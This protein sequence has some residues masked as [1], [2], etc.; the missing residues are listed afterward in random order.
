M[1]IAHAYGLVPLYRERA[2]LLLLN[3]LSASLAMQTLSV[4]FNLIHYAV[5]ASNGIGSPGTSV[6]AGGLV[7]LFEIV[8][9]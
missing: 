2:M 9:V 8:F 7:S 5:F 6:L 1:G 4:T 3:L